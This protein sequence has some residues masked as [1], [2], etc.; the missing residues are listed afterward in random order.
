MIHKLK[1]HQAGSFKMEKNMSFMHQKSSPNSIM[2]NFFKKPVD[3][4]SLFGA[5][6][7]QISDI[8]LKTGKQTSDE[9]GS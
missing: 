7:E 9:V 8:S 2:G 5:E 1:N 6:K 4:D 3:A